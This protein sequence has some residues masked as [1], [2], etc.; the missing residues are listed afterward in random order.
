MYVCM[1]VWMDGWMETCSIDTLKEG[2]GAQI[3]REVDNGRTRNIPVL[4]PY[5]RNLINLNTWL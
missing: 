3:S 4:A 5:M 2:P 1:Y